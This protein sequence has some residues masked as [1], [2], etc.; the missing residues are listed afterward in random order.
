MQPLL[1]NYREKE[2]T[3]LAEPPEFRTPYI[4]C[5]LPSILVCLLIEL[6]HPNTRPQTLF[7]KK[8]TLQLQ[9][10]TASYPSEQLAVK[11]RGGGEKMASDNEEVE[12]G[13]S[14]PYQ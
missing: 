9:W 7:S 10:D 1:Y 11:G 3:F 13:N 2:V 6:I 12:K 14:S 8:H 4:G 5:L